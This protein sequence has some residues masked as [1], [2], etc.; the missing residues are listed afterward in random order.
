MQKLTRERPYSFVGC[1]LL[2]VIN[3]RI[4]SDSLMNVTKDNDH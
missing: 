1:N 2:N 3:D 4:T